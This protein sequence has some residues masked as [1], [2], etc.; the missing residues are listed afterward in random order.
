MPKGHVR[1]GNT[2]GD[3]ASEA[4]IIERYCSS[5]GSNS[6][7]LPATLRATS[8]AACFASSNDADASKAQVSPAQALKL[9]VWAGVAVIVVPSGQVTVTRASP[10]VYT[11][12]S[13]PRVR[14]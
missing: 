10:A 5:G 8:W 13:A 2:I 3:L 1:S 9:A 12:L 6:G 7:W 11:T 14:R 4:G